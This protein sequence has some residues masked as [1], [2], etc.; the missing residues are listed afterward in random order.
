MKQEIKA[1]SAEDAGYDF[2]IDEKVLCD[3][4]VDTIE[5]FI[6]PDDA[7]NWE[8][9]YRVQLEHAGTQVWESISKIIN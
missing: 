6:T 8:M 2:E 5:L 7:E 4:K 3:G 1:I 9:G